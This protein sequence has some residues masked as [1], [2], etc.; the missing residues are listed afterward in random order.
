MEHR[1][2]SSR[3]PCAL[4]SP[5]RRPQRGDS[6]RGTRSASR[7]VRLVTGSAARLPRAPCS[8]P[9]AP[10]ERLAGP[11]SLSADAKRGG[12]WRRLYGPGR[13]GPDRAG[14]SVRHPP[15]IHPRATGLG[16]RV[17]TPGRPRPGRRTVARRR[18]RG[19]SSRAAVSRP[20][21]GGDRMDSPL[22]LGHRGLTALASRRVTSAA[23]PVTGPGSSRAMTRSSPSEQ[24]PS[25]HQ[26]SHRRQSRT[27]ERTPHDILLFPKTGG[28]TESAAGG[29]FSYRQIS[30]CRQFSASGC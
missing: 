8:R 25:P 5:R 19:D 16:I 1:Q 6:D 21:R 3:G 17:T 20:V 7:P 30:R 11:A 4:R 12:W 22:R 18:A 27:H 14:P 26:P 28:P 29:R 13:A 10:S 23:D 2:V 15:H 9:L 24:K